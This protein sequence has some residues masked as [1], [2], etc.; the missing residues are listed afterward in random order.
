MTIP[1]MQFVESRK[2]KDTDTREESLHDFEGI[3]RDRPTSSRWRIEVT[4]RRR[5]RSEKAQGASEC[6]DRNR[7]VPRDGVHDSGVPTRRVEV[8]VCKDDHE[9]E[10][11]KFDGDTVKMVMVNEESTFLSTVNNVKA[12]SKGFWL[13]GNKDRVTRTD[14]TRAECR[15][16]ESCRASSAETGE[17][18]QRIQQVRVAERSVEH[19]RTRTADRGAACRS[20]EG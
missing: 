7:R 15:G 14:E 6:S 8:N 2:L 18:T 4:S 9:E 19:R 12:T 11:A 20:A 10:I 17:E 5:R 13:G 16:A 1:Q 3:D